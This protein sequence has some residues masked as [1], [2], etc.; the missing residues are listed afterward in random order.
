MKLHK[1]K[2]L[3][4]TGPEKSVKPLPIFTVDG[5][6]DENPRFK[7]VV[8]LAIYNSLKLNIDALFIASNAPGRSA[9]NRVKREMAPLKRELLGLILPHD[10]F[11]A[12]LNSASRT[13]DANGGKKTLVSPEKFS[14]VYGQD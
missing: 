1:F 5:G 6:P 14:L 11:G 9:Y 3:T 8:P 12:H 4:K 10:H 2:S 7:T 13:V